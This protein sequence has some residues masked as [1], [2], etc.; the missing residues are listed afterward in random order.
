[1]AKTQAIKSSSKRSAPNASPSGSAADRADLEPNSKRLKRA[2]RS[3]SSKCEEPYLL[4]SDLNPPPPASSPSSSEQEFEE[5]SE[6]SSEDDPEETL[7][8]D[9]EMELEEELEELEEELEE[10]ERKLEDEGEGTDYPQPCKRKSNRKKARDIPWPKPSNS[11]VGRD[12]A[13]KAISKILKGRVTKKDYTKAM[14]VYQEVYHKARMDRLR[15]QQIER[16]L[17][18]KKR[19]SK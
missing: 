3:A 16:G 9:S 1:M 10:W 7:E 19:N 18:Y 14:K 5:E 15:A 11:T 17:E 4:V 2:A 12:A 13:R 8:E 6:S